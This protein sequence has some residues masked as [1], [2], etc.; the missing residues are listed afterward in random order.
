HID[1]VIRVIH[2]GSIVDKEPMT[3]DGFRLPCG[4]RPASHARLG[5]SVEYLAGIGPAPVDHSKRA[6][7]AA[8]GHEPIDIRKSRRQ[9]LERY[10]SRLASNRSSTGSLSIAPGNRS[11][12]GP[13]PPWAEAR[14]S[15]PS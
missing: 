3:V 10:H 12:A 8:S 6:V 15:R 2:L 14:D 13:L 9:G 1:R 11:G 5:C 4:Y 7:L